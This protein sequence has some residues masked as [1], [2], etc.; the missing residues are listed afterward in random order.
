MTNIST[1]FAYGFYFAS[2]TDSKF[3]WD[4]IKNMYLIIDNIIVNI[5]ASNKLIKNVSILLFEIFYLGDF[6]RL[7]KF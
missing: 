5:F 7:F 4:I 3:A 1:L 6:N 2:Y